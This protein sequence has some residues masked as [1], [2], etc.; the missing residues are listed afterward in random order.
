MIHK[1]SN[2]FEENGHV[3]MPIE[4]EPIMI[5]PSGCESI[6]LWGW[7]DPQEPKR[8]IKV[9]SCSELS[10]Y[11]K[12][13]KGDWLILCEPWIDPPRG[14]QQ[15]VSTL[16]DPSLAHYSFN[17][18]IQPPETMPSHLVPPVEVLDC[19]VELIKVDEAT[20]LE[21]AALND[22][23]LEDKWHWKIKIKEV[24]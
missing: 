20:Q 4:S 11:S 3:I 5:E 19:E 10:Q 21:Q 15:L 13:K 12:Y 17:N 24:I 6:I 2:Y 23:Y 8:I 16:D 1:I 18:K 22:I 7:P 14:K 9:H